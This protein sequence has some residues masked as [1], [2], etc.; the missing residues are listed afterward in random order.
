MAAAAPVTSAPPVVPLPSATLVP[1]PSVPTALSASSWLATASATSKDYTLPAPWIRTGANSWL[2]IMDGSKKMTDLYAACG[3]H[4]EQL[5]HISFRRLQQSD[6]MST[7][8]RYLLAL[9]E[10]VQN[11]SVEGVAALFDPEV[12]KSSVALCRLRRGRDMKAPVGL[13][14]VLMGS[15]HSSKKYERISALDCIPDD[16]RLH[17]PIWPSFVASTEMQLGEYAHPVHL[18]RWRLDSKFPMIYVAF[19]RCW[20]GIVRVRTSHSFRTS[21]IPHMMSNLFFFFFFSFSL[22]PSD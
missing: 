12:V 21:L 19:I 13:D 8:M 11:M 7:K 4:L 16:L 6:A 1:L 20:D 9:V 2:A 15:E 3:S 17:C 5:D 14:F 18:N 10:K 22:D